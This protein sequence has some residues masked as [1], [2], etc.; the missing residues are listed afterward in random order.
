MRALL[1]VLL[2]QMRSLAA[3]AAVVA[4]AAAGLR[5]MAAACGGGGAQ[6]K[7]SGE[8]KPSEG[9][10]THSRIIRGQGGGI[11][12]GIHEREGGGE[13]GGNS[14]LWSPKI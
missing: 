12:M 4:A 14:P 2:L 7:P 10:Y 1:L 8:K 9:T 13:R 5:I 11:P 3:A 6:E